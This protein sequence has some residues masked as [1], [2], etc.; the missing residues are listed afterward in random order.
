ME[1]VV[2]QLNLFYAEILSRKYDI[3]GNIKAVVQNLLCKFFEITGGHPIVIHVVKVVNYFLLNT[4]IHTSL[5]YSRKKYF[6]FLTV[7]SR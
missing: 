4:K 6:R 2:K 7:F 5:A 1:S 3:S